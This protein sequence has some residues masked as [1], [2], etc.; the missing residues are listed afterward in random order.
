MPGPA[1]SAKSRAN[2]PGVDVVQFG[3]G[4]VVVTIV[5]DVVARAIV[6]DYRLP[7]TLLSSSATGESLIVSLI[8]PRLTGVGMPLLRSGQTRR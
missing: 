6:D 5:D 8:S 7:L 4:V 3:S 2:L 1:T